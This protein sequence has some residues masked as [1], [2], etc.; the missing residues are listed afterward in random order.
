MIRLDKIISILERLVKRSELTDSNDFL[1]D[2]TEDAKKELDSFKNLKFE[3]YFVV[4]WEYAQGV[5]EELNIIWKPLR[6]SFLEDHHEI[7]AR[8][9]ALNKVSELSTKKS[10]RNVSTKL[11]ANI[12]EVCLEEYQS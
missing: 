2:I 7:P 1:T 10:V 12:F 5:D 4:S 6:M 9:R 11:C 8:E 3:K